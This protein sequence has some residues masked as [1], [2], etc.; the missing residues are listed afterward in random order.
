MQITSD[1][2]SVLIL[3]YFL[4]TD[5]LLR[6]RD[7]PVSL[8]LPLVREEDCRL[9]EPRKLE[10]RSFPPLSEP[11]KALSRFPVRLRSLVCGPLLSLSP[12]PRSYPRE[13]EVVTL[14]VSPKGRCPYF[15][16]VA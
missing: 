2:L 4:L 12:R 9:S 13:S 15:L 6:P 8:E 5:Y 16:A 7:E 3:F 11:L 10:A 14:L 1:Q